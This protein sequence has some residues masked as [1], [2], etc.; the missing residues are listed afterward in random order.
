MENKKLIFDWDCLPKWANNFICMSP[1]GN[2][3]FSDTQ[4][5]FYS[6][7]NQIPKHYEPKGFDGEYFNS[8]T[9]NPNNTKIKEVFIFR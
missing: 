5:I 8:M 3:Y 1:K 7:E 6:E 2:W 4:N 9:E